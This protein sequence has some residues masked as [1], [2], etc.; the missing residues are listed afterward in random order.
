MNSDQ[1]CIEIEDRFLEIK[2]VD[3]KTSKLTVNPCT[4]RVTLKISKDASD[5]RYLKEIANIAMTTEFSPFTHRGIIKLNKFDNIYQV[6]VFTGKR[7]KIDSNV[8]RIRSS[9]VS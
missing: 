8:V 2:Y 7:M 4:G 3:S 1:S 6:V 9:I 5:E